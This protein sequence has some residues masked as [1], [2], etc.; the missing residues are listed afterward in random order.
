MK[1]LLAICALMLCGISYAQESIITTTVPVSK[2]IDASSWAT[3][4]ETADFKIEYIKVDCDPN[5]GMDFE[6]IILRFKNL[7]SNEITLDWHWDLVYDVTCRTCGYDEY[8]RTLTLAPNEVKEGDCNVKT[9]ITL[10]LFVRFIDA[11]YSKGEELTPFTM[12]DLT[13]SQ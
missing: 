4:V 6:G 3:Y 7:T 8:D 5:S 9:N 2:N 10:D 13:I 1:A 11:A 12:T